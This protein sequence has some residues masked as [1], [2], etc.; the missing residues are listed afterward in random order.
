MNRNNE[1]GRQPGRMDV[2]EGTA[3]VV[4]LFALWSAASFGVGALIGFPFGS[5]LRT[6][7][8]TLLAGV[9][10]L[11][12]VAL[13]R[14]SARTQEFVVV[15][16]MLKF[17]DIKL[18]GLRLAFP[19]IDR[20]RLRDNFLSKQIELFVVN[21]TPATRAG[22][23]FVDATAPVNAGAWY[24]VGDPEAV[25]AGDYEKLIQDVYR[26]VY[27]IFE[28]SRAKRIADIIEDALRPIL[29]KYTLDAAQ[30]DADSAGDLCVAAA[31]PRLAELGVYASPGKGVVIRD[32]I[33]PPE[34]AELRA[35]ALRG[36]KRA[37]EIAAASTGYWQSISEVISGA[38][39]S[40][41]DLTTEEAR[42]IVETQRGLEVVEKTGANITFVSPNVRGV[43]TTLGIGE[44][45]EKKE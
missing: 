29:Q 15:E 5:S 33:I 45:E 42:A 12:A 18:S 20:I 4:A 44:K 28:D 17:W 32:I 43:L 25:M 35:L 30:K 3:W 13:Y 40:G 41:K 9:G 34:I 1:T 31:R 37:E 11:Y 2:S 6:G 36:K 23:D 16:R 8:S 38:E 27:V 21:G 26:Y 19:F 22:I 7:F 39:K 24:Q 14:G 10:I